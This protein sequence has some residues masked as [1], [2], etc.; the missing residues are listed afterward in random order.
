MVRNVLEQH[1]EQEPRRVRPTLSCLTPSGTLARASIDA[2]RKR[3]SV[4]MSGLSGISV[5]S[6]ASPIIVN[7]GGR[8]TTNRAMSPRQSRNLY[9]T[10]CFLTVTFLLC[11]LPRIVLNV[12]EVPMSKR[13]MLCNQLFGKNFFSPPW[14]LILAS[15]EK[16]TL[17]I[18][19]SINFV[20]YCLA[21]K[22]FRQQMFKVRLFWNY[23][24]FNPLDDNKILFIDEIRS[25]YDPSYL[26]TCIQSEL[27]NIQHKYH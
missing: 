15:V 16:L 14:V 3:S 27:R 26:S 24:S 20:F 4:S 22:S 6:G 5:N 21:G 23:M 8:I 25:M 19:S 10:F 12:Y 7:G 2:I 11:H 9:M 13:R 17:I 1:I 18:N